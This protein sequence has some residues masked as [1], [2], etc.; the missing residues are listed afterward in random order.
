MEKQKNN[1]TDAND[2]LEKIEKPSYTY[3]KRES[4]QPFS[5]DFIPQKSQSSLAQQEANST[6][7]V[8]SA[9]NKA[10]TW[11]YCLFFFIKILITKIKSTLFLFLN[12]TPD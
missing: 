9:W 2:D 6:S 10:G 8:G 3:W 11:Y 1:S 12:I 7:T 5:K 4:D